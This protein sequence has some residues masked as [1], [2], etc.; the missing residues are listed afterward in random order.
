MADTPPKIPARGLLRRVTKRVL[1]RE[2]QKHILTLECGHVVVRSIGQQHTR[3]YCTE[4]KEPLPKT[5]KGERKPEPPIVGISHEK[6]D[7]D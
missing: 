2:K 5:R 7:D 4:C 6:D 1:D 3:S